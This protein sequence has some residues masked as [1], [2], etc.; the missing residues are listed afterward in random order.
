MSRLGATTAALAAAMLISAGCG[1]DGRLRVQDY[2]PRPV[3]D[4]DVVG[5]RMTPPAPVNWDE[6]P[7]SDGLQIQVNFFRRDEDL[8]V[9]VRGSLELTLYAGRLQA[10]QLAEARPLRT[11]RF[12]GVELSTYCGKSAFGWGYA[13]RLPW[14]SQAPPGSNATLASRYISPDGRVVP[15]RPIIVPLGPQ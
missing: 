1:G 7:G 4:V 15:G 9:I 8:S 5:L 12:D 2:P 3:D 14:G 13:M 6:R 11:W 10:K